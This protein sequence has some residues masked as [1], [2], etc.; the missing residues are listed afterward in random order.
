MIKYLPIS[1][2]LFLYSLTRPNYWIFLSHTSPELNWPPLSYA[3]GQALFT[4]TWIAFSKWATTVLWSKHKLSDILKFLILNRL[5]INVIILKVA[6][7]ILCFISWTGNWGNSWINCN[8]QFLKVPSIRVKFIMSVDCYYYIIDGKN[9]IYNSCPI[10][11][12][13]IIWRKS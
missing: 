2:F 10:I 3:D 8:R 9:K 13:Y 1:E 11:C 6:M 12:Y 7:R 4:E 5:Q